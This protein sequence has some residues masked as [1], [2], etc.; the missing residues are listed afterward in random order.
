[1]VNS[2][3]PF[4]QKNDYEKDSTKNNNGTGLSYFNGS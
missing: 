4:L 3:K 2:R 1:M